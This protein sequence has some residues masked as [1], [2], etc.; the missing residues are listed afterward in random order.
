M[1]WNSS[2]RGSLGPETTVINVE[3]FGVRQPF[4][5]AVQDVSKRGYVLLRGRRELKWILGI[6]VAFISFQSYFVRQLLAALFF[7]TIFYVILAA[8]V[9]L[10]IL[11]VDALDCGSVWVESLGRSFLSLVCHHFASPARV[12]VVPKVENHIVI[13]NSAMPRSTRPNGGS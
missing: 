8:L 13:R 2:P 5:S 4:F 9:A 3:Q 1:Q 12:P 7:F 6:L 11:I 10:Y